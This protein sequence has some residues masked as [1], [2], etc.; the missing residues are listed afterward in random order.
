MNPARIFD[1]LKAR[2]TIPQ[3]AAYYG[4]KVDRS[5]MCRCPFHSDK[6]P[7]MKINETYYYCFGC[8][9]TG[10]VIDFTARLFNLSPLDAACKLAAD[11]GIDPNTPV[12]AAVAP[13]HIRQEES[14]REREG[15]CAS[16]LIE[17]ERL[18]KNRQRRF[19][20]VHPS[21]EWDDRFVSAS[22]ALPQVSYL[23]DC[24]CDADSVIRKDTADSLIS[25]GTLHSIERWNTTHREEVDAHDEALA[26]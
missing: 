15:R 13:P 20:P 14:M 8:H 9:T 24:L 25:D 12:S 17:Y 22:H 5:D 10:D 3:A 19:A 21:E 6:T 26:A 23:I 16:V 11:F 2:I 4:V 7:S 18:L 1:T